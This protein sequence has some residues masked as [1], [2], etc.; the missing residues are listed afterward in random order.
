MKR[1]SFIGYCALD[2]GRRVRHTLTPQGKYYRIRFMRPNAHLLPRSQKYVDRLV[3]ETRQKRA[4]EP[5]EAI[6]REVYEGKKEGRQGVSWDEAINNLTHRIR[7]NNNKPATLKNYQDVLKL[8]R[9]FYPE[10][11]GPGDID[12]E[13][14]RAFLDH[15]RLEKGI[16]IRT[17][18]G[19]LCALKSIW[20]KWWIDECKLLPK[21]TN[22]WEEIKHIKVPKELPQPITD[23]EKEAF[24]DWLHRKLDGW[25]LPLLY[26]EVQAF[27]GCRGGELAGTRTV[28]LRDGRIYIGVEV[29]KTHQERGCLLPPAVYA[30]LLLVSEGKEYLFE[31]FVEE[32]PR[33]C[34]SKYWDRLAK[35]FSPGLFHRFMR[36]QKQRYLMEVYELD[37]IG[38]FRLD[39]RYFRLHN[40]RGTAM[41]KAKERGVHAEQAKEFFGCSPK[42]MAQHYENFDR[43][44]QADEVAARL[45]GHLE[46]R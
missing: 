19:D 14:A 12:N 2:D 43:L 35:V 29:N 27:A 37:K 38:T 23:Q 44:A 41:S 10:S 16:A 42:T 20:G 40:F 28:N 33:Y 1:T 21:G 17:Y 31:R 9:D 6:I 15:R 39:R 36:Q 13:K 32:R 22:P 26:L 8:L 34:R 4:C 30:E 24:F 7:V 18:N 3:Y 25:R 5:A 46:G 11:H 45:M